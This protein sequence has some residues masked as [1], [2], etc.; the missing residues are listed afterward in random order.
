MA[1]LTAKYK[2]NET[3]LAAL[4]QIVPEAFKDNEL[5]FNSLYEALSD[6]IDD[7]DEADID[8]YGLSWPGKRA[9]KRAAA[10]PPLGTLVPVPG[11]GV[12]EVTTRNIYIEGDNLEILKIMRKAY[13]GRI[14]MIYIDPPYNTGNDFI[15]PDDFSESVE[16]YQR[17]TGQV[18]E[19][20]VR[21]TTN[22]RSD[23]RFHSKWLSMMYPRLRLVR[24]LLSED[25]AIFISIEDNE[26]AQLRK[27][28]DEIFGEE[29]FVAIVPR[30]AKRTSDKG[31]HF[32][33]TKDYI[34]C[35]AKNIS[36]LPEF[37]ILK[38]R[39]EKEYDM[40]EAD[41]RRYKK[42]GA[43]L[44]QPSLDSRPNQ[45]Y[46]IKAP[47]GSLIIPPGNVF[48]IEKED[49]AK[50][51]PQSN[52][53]KVWRWS[54]DSYL[55]QKHLL[56]FTKG[57]AQNPLLD[58]NGKPSRWN[59][60]PKVYYDEDI[61]ST[62]HPEDVI[63]DYPNSQ[64]AKEL[65]VL[66]IPFDFAKPSGLICFLTKLLDDPKMIVL[67]FFSGSATT[68]HAV[69]Q[70]NA[71][72]GGNRQ[73]IMVQLQEPCKEDS[74]AAKAGF[75]NI[76]E[77]G[78]ER[79]RR[80]GKKIKQ[81]A[82]LNAAHLDTGFKVFCLAPSNYKAWENYKGTDIKKL[83][84]L[85]KEDSLKQGWKEDDLLSEVMLIEGFPLDS[86]IEPLTQFTKNKIK[87]ISSD[88]HENT[89]YICLD[90]KIHK[91]TVNALM[92]TDRDRFICLDSAVDD[93]TKIRLEDKN[94]IKT[95]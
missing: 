14:K 46:Y 26:V 43:S 76:C 7:D 50:I 95:L 20:G 48:P 38:E 94:L 63:Y 77:I 25:G 88:F 22:N 42:S 75:K 69:M 58:E 36:S 21:M 37:G 27:I 66:D 83:E 93:E 80:A 62:L 24:D 44:Y 29:N 72:D 30:I 1:K 33:P 3:Q 53:D 17:R 16:S 82:G 52:V 86:K 5:D 81:E 19:N 74:E 61:T 84:E 59:I 10:I 31:T 47:D 68:A 11:D 12:D 71:E 91:E 41:G 34:I 2:L 67:D 23:G 6:Y 55:K 39:E 8:Q 40:I 18:D 32:K 54:V 13:E 79:I 15:Y 56:I 35:F 9:A 45:R 49:A 64:A 70:L 4:R 87:K 51:K 78:K 92:L 60:Y 85:F 28:C 57:S 90:K 89:I 65:N 73:F